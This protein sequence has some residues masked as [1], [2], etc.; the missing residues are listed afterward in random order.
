MGS[1]IPQQPDWSAHST[2]VGCSVAFVSNS[3]SCT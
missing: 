1:D 3:L 2:I